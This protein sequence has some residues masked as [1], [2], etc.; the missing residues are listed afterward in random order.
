MPGLL[1]SSH[2]TALYRLFHAYTSLVH[3]RSIRLLSLDVE[4][5][6]GE[7]GGFAF[8]SPGSI[9]EGLSG[10]HPSRASY[11]SGPGGVCCAVVRLLAPR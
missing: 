9:A 3:T 11:G 2:V 4:D 10:N 1:T 5:V 7:F 6:D 8:W